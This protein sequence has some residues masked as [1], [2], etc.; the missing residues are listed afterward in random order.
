MTT[1]KCDRCKRYFDMD[2]RRSEAKIV[3]PFAMPI[4]MDL[5]PDCTAQLLSWIKNEAEFFE[6]RGLPTAYMR[7]EENG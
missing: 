2:V 1:K 7:G 6:R 5:C 3:V 4:N